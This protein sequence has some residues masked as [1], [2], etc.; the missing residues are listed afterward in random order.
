MRKS[1]HCLPSGPRPSR[2]RC[3]REV[4]RTRKLG[5]CVRLGGIDVSQRHFHLAPAEKLEAAPHDRQVLLRHRPPSFLL[6]VGFANGERRAQPSRREA[7]PLPPPSQISDDQQLEFHE[8][9]LDADSFEDLPGKWQAAIVMA[10][11]SRPKLQ[12]VSD[13]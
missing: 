5:S 9:L 1:S 10:E 11:R 7:R 2:A 6:S 8:V 3:A 4:R 12:L 13:G